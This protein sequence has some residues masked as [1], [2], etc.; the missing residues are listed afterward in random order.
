MYVGLMP[1]PDKRYHSFAVVE[2][3]VLMHRSIIHAASIKSRFLKVK[4]ST[5]NRGQIITYEILYYVLSYMYLN[6]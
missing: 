3:R 2:T 5:I 4:P 1:L 6:N